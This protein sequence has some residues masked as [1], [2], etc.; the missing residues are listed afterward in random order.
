MKVLIV[1]NNLHIKTYPQTMLIRQ[2]LG[3]AHGITATTCLPHQLADNHISYDRVILSGST[4]Y[5]REEKEWMDH[6]RRFIDRWI[7]KQ[8]PILG[9]CFGAQLLARHVF[10]KE[11]VVAL[12]YPINGSIIVD[13]INNSPLF[14]SLPPSFGAVATHYEGFSVP[15]SC[16]I[17]QTAE[18]HSYGFQMDGHIFGIQFH[19]ELTGWFGKQLVTIQ[20]LL[21]DRHVYQSFSVKTDPWHG[22]KIFRN[23]LTLPA[24]L[25]SAAKGP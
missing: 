19:P 3:I 25:S 17:A 22:K 13:Q 20:R 6:E 11:A 12:P 23:F 4:A 2:Y 21:Y 5:I 18:W 14:A 10:G 9:I 7:Q 8:V 1:D 24:P 16:R 15:A